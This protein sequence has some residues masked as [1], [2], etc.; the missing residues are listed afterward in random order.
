MLT[1]GDIDSSALDLQQEL[2]SSYAKGSFWGAAASVVDSA[3]SN[4]TNYSIN[5][6][7]LAYQEATNDKNEA[8]MRESWSRDD[9]AVQRRVADLKAAGISPLLAAG[10]AAGNSGAIQLNAPHNDFRLQGSPL[11]SALTASQTIKGLALDNRLKELQASY[12]GMPDWLTGILRV[13]NETPE[14]NPVRQALIK[15]LG[16][17]TG[18]QSSDTYGSNSSGSP[19]KSDYNPLTGTA[20]YLVPGTEYEAKLTSG[21]VNDLRDFYHKFLN[22]VSSYFDNRG[23]I[24]SRGEELIDFISEHYGFTRDSASRII[25]A[26]YFNDTGSPVGLG[27]GYAW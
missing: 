27:G 14:D 12:F 8:L 5:K 13:I 4:I 22:N 6:K 21:Q 10:S 20:T 17:I 2:G 24:T 15:G 26:W 18:G 23:N 19:S 25:F 7:N 11:L 9:N 3:I 1:S 16:F